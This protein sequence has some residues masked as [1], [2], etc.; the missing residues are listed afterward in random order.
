MTHRYNRKDLIAVLDDTLDVADKRFRHSLEYESINRIKKLPEFYERKFT[1]KVT[2]NDCMDDIKEMAAKYGNGIAVNS[3]SLKN[4]GGG[5]VKGSSAQEE[6]MC[7]R[8]NLFMAIDNIDH[9]MHYPL[10]DKTIGMYIPE[11]TFFKKSREY[12]YEEDDAYVSN[13]VNL[14]SRPVGNIRESSFE[15]HCNAFQP[16]VYFANKYKAKYLVIPPIGCGVFGHDPAD[17]SHAL[18]KVLANFQLE[19]VEEIVI[20][21]YTGEY[22]YQAFSWAFRDWL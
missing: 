10:H 11:V 4:P 8:S 21:C 14:Y 3:A 1:F 7:R 18:Y 15:Y 5:V 19:T 16:L 2:N 22:T 17:V 6:E 20:S 12:D 9:E 13:V